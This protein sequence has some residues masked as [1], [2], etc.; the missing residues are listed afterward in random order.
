MTGNDI[1]KQVKAV[2]ENSYFKLVERIAIGVLVYM[3]SQ[4]LTELKESRQAI[5]TA[6][7]E[8]SAITVRLTN[9]E[10]DVDRIHSHVFK[11]RD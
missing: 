8:R 4:V 11:L 5:T 1:N 10:Q 7:A 2:A 6:L 3:G 9:I